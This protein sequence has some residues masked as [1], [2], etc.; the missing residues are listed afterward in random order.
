MSHISEVLGTV[1]V[2]KPLS[3]GE[4]CTTVSRHVD[5]PLNSQK[6]S[7]ADMVEK[8]CEFDVCNLILSVTS[9]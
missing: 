3:V 1:E 4:E 5:F 7:Q 9:Q 8:K 2:M 6:A